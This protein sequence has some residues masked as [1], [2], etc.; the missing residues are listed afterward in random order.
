M[1]FF[2][3]STDGDQSDEDDEVQTTNGLLGEDTL[4][5]SV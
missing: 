2:L 4:G 5:P 1:K 3:G